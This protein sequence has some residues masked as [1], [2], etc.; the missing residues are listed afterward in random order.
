MRGEK[1]EMLD[2]RMRLV[3]AELASNAQQDRPRLRAARREF[4]LALADVGLHV[5]EPLEK[6]VVPGDAAILA[7]GD[8][9]EADVLL[10]VDQRPD[11][12]ILDLLERL[13]AQFAALAF[14]PRLFERG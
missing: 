3:A 8:R 13:L 14:F 6:I 11:L 5:V 10:L 2:H 7:V 1:L 9:V 12:A 4:N